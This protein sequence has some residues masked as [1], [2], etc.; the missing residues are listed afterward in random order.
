MNR[1]YRSIW[2]EVAR[3]FIAAAENV[4]SRGAPSASSRAAVP[5]DAG[6][7][8]GRTRRSAVRPLALEQRFMFDGAAVATGMEAAAE[9]VRATPDAA[10]ADHAVTPQAVVFVDARVQDKETLLANI[11]P[12]A[13]VVVLD[14]KSDGLD[15][16]AAYLAGHHNVGSVQIVAH[17]WEGNLWL[18]NTFVDQASLEAHKADLSTIGQALKPGG[19]ILVY[20]CDTAAGTDGRAFV[21]TLSQLTGA[22]VAA[23]DNR[24][25]SGGD[26][27]LEIAT[28]SIEAVPMLSADAMA[29]Y[30]H[31]LA[32][33]TVTKNADDGS[34]G[35]L[36]YEIGQAVAGDTI[37]FTA[38]MTITLSGGYLS[39]NKDLTIE[40][41]IDGNGTA[42][43][44]LD[45]A[46]QTDL[47]RVGST[48]TLDGLIL[49]HGLLA[50]KGGS[51]IIW[52]DGG[53]SLGAAISVQSGT[54]MID[55][56]QIIGNVATG[57]G[58][59]GFYSGGGGSGFNG[60]G[61]G[62][63]GD[64]PYGLNGNGG[65]GGGDSRGGQGGTSGLSGSGGA[66]GIA[67]S[68]GGAGGT[69][70]DATI[71]FAGGG[72]GG[73]GID[74]SVGT[75]NNGGSAVGGLYIAGGA[76]VFML[77]TSFS[78]NL[79]AGGGGGGS[80][81]YRA[82]GNGGAGA[83]GI[84]VKGWLYYQ[85]STTSFTHNHGAGGLAGADEYYKGVGNDGAS[86][87]NVLNR[88]GS[89]FSTWSL[90]PTT[91]ISTVHFSNDTAANNTSN[92]DLVTKTASQTI[93]GT[94]SA[95]LAVGETV[96]V[97]LDNGST[98]TNATAS[99]GS[100]SWSLAGVNLSGSGTLKVKISNSWTDGS[101][102]SQ[103][104]V[105][106]TTAPATTVSSAALSADTGA[107]GVSNTDFITKTTAQTIS[108]ALSA[109]LAAGETVYVSLDNGS[110]WTAATATVGQNTWSL[111]G[112]TLSGSNTLQV[113]VTDTA[114]NDGA[115]RSQAYVLDQS[116]PT[117]TVASVAFSNDTG[118]SGGDFL[119]KTAS[120]TISG[121]LSA[122]LAAG[123]TVYVSLDNGAHWTAATATAGQSTWSL[124]GQTLTGSDTLKVKVSD[125]AGN[126]GAIRSQA[127][128]LDTTGPAITFGGVALS[129]D[130]GSNGSDFI[131]ATA[132]QTITAT[133]SSAPGGT[134]IVYGSLDNG[135][136]WTNIT[137]KV[138]STT[139]NWD[140]VNL[141]G[142]NTLLLKVTDAA[143]N[144]GTVF[145]KAYV[146]DQIAPVAPSAPDLTAASDAG[147]LNND[148]L[149][150]VTAPVFTGTAEAD[151]TVTLYDTD[152][153]TVL[154]STT[155]TGGN[156]TIT[157]S[158]LTA[159][160]HTVTAKTTDAAGNVSAASAGLAVVIET[161]PP[162]GLAVSDTTIPSITATSGATIATL[163]ATDA[164]SITYALATGDGS[165]D[166]QNARFAVVGNSLK[167]G[168]TALTAGTYHLYVKATDAAGNISY[169]AFVLNV[170]D[171]PSVTSV[172]RT[173]GASATVAT[174]AAS[175]DYT[176]T[177]DQAVT[178]VDASD[179]L[180]TATGTASGNIASVT[181]SGTTWTVRVDTLGGDGTLRLDLK[182]S[183]TG[184]K[185][186]SSV[187]ILGGYAAGATYTLDHTAPVAPSAPDMTAGTDSGIL[188]NDN[189]TNNTAPV[190]TGTA[191]AGSTV[192]LYD[193]D[194]T[195]VLG[196]TTATG[197]NWTIT[198]STL[199]AGSHTITAKAV[200]AAGNAS[201]ASAGL[202]VTID[203]TAPGVASV[204]VPAD[205]S[206]KAGQTLSF[207][208]NSGEAITVDTSTGT[209]RL[210][211]DI[212]GVTRYATYASGS[213]S[214]ALVFTYTVQPGDTDSDGIAVNA[215]QSNSGTL[216]DTAGNGLTLTL[217]SVGSTAGVL[218][219][220]TAPTVNS[221]SVPANG[222]YYNGQ[223]LDFTVNFSEAVTV[224]TTGG[225]PR[226]AITLD[227]GGTVYADYVSG[228]GTSSLVF[229]HTVANGEKD[230][231]GI[232]V[233]ALSANGGT[234]RDIAGNDATPTLNGVGS[235]AGV[236]VDGSQPSILNVTSTTADGD[237]KAGATITV[238]VTFSTAVNV[239]T[240]GGVPALALGGGGTATYAGGS[241]TDTLTFTYTVGA[242]ENSADLDYASTAALSLNGATIKDIHGSHQNAVLTL[243]TPGAAGSLGANK[244][245]VV[246]TTPPAITFSNPAL[247]ADTG[248]S[249]SD[250]ITSAAGQTIT[251]TLSGM[252]AGTDKIY[253]SLDNGATWT[254]ITGKVAGTT[255]TWDGVTL[256]GSGVLKLK[257]NDAAGN[258][259]TV[260]SRAYTLD[261]TAPNSPSAPDLAAASDSGI[262]NSDDLTRITTPTVTG[263]A[264]TGST[265]ALY[266]TNGTT[267][268]GTAT[269]DGAGNWSIT[270]S[271]LSAGV[272]TLTAK[273]TDAAG[274]TSVASA[275]L[276]VTIDTAA[277]AAP[278]AP[279][280]AATSDSGIS[281]SDN[282]TRT[283]TPT[284][285]GTAEAGSTVTLYDSDG[286]TVL[287]T[288]TADGAG[289][290]SITASAL[291]D[292]VHTLTTKATDGAGNTSAAS[293]GL[294]VTIDAAAPAAP[295]GLDL[296]AASDSGTSG[297]DNFTRITTPTITG[298]A[299]AGST[300]ALYDSDG[301]T[302]L[303]TATADGSGRWSITASALS[304]G[305][306]ILTA[307][308][309][310]AAGNTSSASA[311]LAVTIDTAG[312]VV[313]VDAV[314]TGSMTPVL[315]GTAN[316]GTLTVTVG[317]A[318]YIVIPANGRWSLDLATA[319]P[320]SGRLAVTPGNS[321]PVTVA[322]IDAAGNAGNAS[323]MLD[324]VVITK[325]PETAP[326]VPT[327]PAP[328]PF[329]ALPTEPAPAPAPLPFLSQPT[330]RIVNGMPLSS[331]GEPG[332]GTSRSSPGGGDKGLQLGRPM[333]DQSVPVG[334][335]AEIRIP[336]DIFAGL[337]VGGA[338]QLSA[339][340]ENGK[341]LPNW[342]WFDAVSGKF[343]VK[344]PP[345]VSGE[346]AV[347][348]T[349]RDPEGRMA[350]TTFKIRV[351]GSRQTGL[352][353]PGR[354]GLSE[355][356]RQAARS[357]GRLDALAQYAQTAYGMRM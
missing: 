159:G 151:S 102:Y 39:I 97:S 154:G 60:Q 227:T 85:G 53:S 221:V 173:G 341:P 117:N 348:L 132:T 23:S 191:E 120:Q 201:A 160:T 290:W 55:H 251:A 214:T 169:Q 297:S 356:L 129:S 233:G 140:G 25:G 267:V 104:Y 123:E 352:E 56:C 68:N 182:G 268:L 306:H 44:T 289:N 109:N 220:T 42:D 107:N 106:D 307:K 126:D 305:V 72:G 308:A 287:G 146:L 256:A 193:T 315:S 105:L 99:V 31:S 64:G 326:S 50:G 188:N 69:A 82:S 36:R 316:E 138:S 345:G 230:I 322:A 313:T 222:I 148:N 336:A 216:K 225:T 147:I 67:V 9:A 340:Q 207:T 302:V 125:T 260:Y 84:M 311:G 314:S 286:T 124:S 194:G 163:S 270:A 75:S 200:D 54:L 93:S 8:S 101:V 143:G 37:T 63:G 142:S 238:T 228:S 351:G 165:N 46:Y 136:T 274:N 186:G 34:A 245:I 312:P 332:F 162:T 177:F 344:A 70:G 282:L 178:G 27:K 299:E 208:V 250:F 206:Y 170:I 335:G 16:M 98:W 298:T 280:L 244:A 300:V 92:T 263:T 292:G 167:V 183:G 277:P 240:A 150:N 112:Q 205:S 337:G 61:G 346:L 19:D 218:V 209:P 284:V 80:S 21:N 196:S 41:D 144:D 76:T 310:D 100:S 190:F 86:D 108:G 343:V 350:A 175:I 331:G 318:T 247:L 273:A 121:T 30:D 28:G 33:L 215:L 185:N 113:K 66:G 110:T 18:G 71:G 219:D 321:Y 353:R 45:G 83:G 127:Y 180:L 7:A 271:A 181:G 179:F 145:S 49:E 3:T 79:G 131:T 198:S 189:L 283:T 258:D 133:L 78:G 278:S 139:L 13:E 52:Y 236:N 10:V 226:I 95:N 294:A 261:T 29:G 77:N 203:T 164:Q 342:V 333:A 265:V 137:S 5:G 90:P 1:T 243:A 325:V 195:T 354:A 74:I 58:G 255:L 174:D 319:V 51:G 40:G 339:V 329:A 73:A 94:L 38:P 59:I 213:G 279:D 118:S 281:S 232:T 192:T 223:N 166:A 231:N 234:L 153:T 269:A 224:D 211:L 301:T 330:E 210:V 304:D 293:A 334:L 6:S 12:K 11:D 349:A 149:T 199:A 202:T 296:I 26:W 276:A 323:G 187:D 295:G 172:V 355:Q 152:G 303:G 249:A 252:R 275:G 119:T 320:A 48:S 317:G 65:A 47:I 176:V 266:D 285:T 264:E 246:D 88:G 235:T 257:V 81:R 17:G 161:T 309:T 128:V 241:G 116:A 22:D 324:V 242:G 254:D 171:G 96:K 20:A 111:A 253:G 338:L 103:A 134:D 141:S 357:T 217:N 197:G 62:K 212:G 156:W 248:S 130:T 15:Q 262:S 204:S 24:T 57:G 122:N 87:D 135:A 35:T 158:A 14:Q 288:A 237:Y 272:H 89:V 157:S 4:R 327:A 291:S 155:A 168:G 347:R 2:N 184:I 259:G 114:G 328:A 91:T 115:I 32:T 229:R 239:D 43:V